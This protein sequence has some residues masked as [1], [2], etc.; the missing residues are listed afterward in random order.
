MLFNSPTQGTGYFFSAPLT[1]LG[2]YVSGNTQLD[3]STVAVAS[4][5]PEPSSLLLLVTGLSGALVLVSTKTMRLLRSSE[6]SA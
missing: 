1:S 4:P 5:V 3:I 2:T 6:L